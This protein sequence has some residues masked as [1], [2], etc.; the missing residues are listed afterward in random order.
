MPWSPLHPVGRA[1]IDGSYNACSLPTSNH[2]LQATPCRNAVPP[3]VVALQES[4][5]CTGI[6][7]YQPSRDQ[8]EIVAGSTATK[9][10]L[11]LKMSVSVDGFV[12]GPNGEMDW[13]FRTSGADS[14]AWVLDTLHGAGVHIMG[15]RSY[16]DM[17]G[18]W[19]YS[20][21]PMAPPRSGVA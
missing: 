16:Q 11:V 18:F 5:I 12:A 8:G 15:S 13:V 17:A 4:G 14:A 1:D 19:P 10:K 7:F 2:P 3:F 6:R 9:R 21:T 20:E